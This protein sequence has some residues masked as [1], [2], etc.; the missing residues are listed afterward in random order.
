MMQSIRGDKIF[1]KPISDPTGAIPSW[2]GEE[3]PVPHK[4]ASEVGEIRRKVGE[5]YEA[6]QKIKEIA[7]TLS[8]E[9]PA[10][11]NTFERAISETYE[12]YE[13]GLPVPNDRLLTIEEW[14]DFIIVNS[15]LGT[16]VNRTLARLVGHLLSD[17][18]GGSVGIQQDPYRFV[19][20][21]VGAIDAEDVVNTL[22]RLGTVNLDETAITASKR[23]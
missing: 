18:S 9:Y 12:Q 3:I 15:H 7:Q 14:D 6:G 4:V 1:V 16:L 20:Q 23:T 10:D 11:P 5:L 21:T 2:V 22:R 8:Q 13:Q 17:E 19:F